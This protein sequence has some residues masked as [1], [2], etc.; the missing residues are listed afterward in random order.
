MDALQI[1]AEPHR[2]DILRLIWRDELAVGSL[3]A[4][5]NLS[6][7]GV[8]QHL[9]KLRQAGLVTVRQEGKQ[10]LYRVDR[11]RLGP[12]QSFLESFWAQS[13]DRLAALA[14][15]AESP[16]RA[17]EARNP[18]RAEQAERGEG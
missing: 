15:E 17:K 7:S 5:L 13:L 2:R 12:L 9:A 10:R 6:Y 11:E 3:A 16:M 18:V 1:I 14:E 4:R 8:S